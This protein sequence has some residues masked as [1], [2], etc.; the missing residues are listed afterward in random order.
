[1]PEWGLNSELSDHWD[2]LRA[3]ITPSNEVSRWRFVLSLSP[4]H[5]AVPEELRECCRALVTKKRISGCIAEV[6]T[7]FPRKQAYVFID[8]HYTAY[9]ACGC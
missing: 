5:K 6:T 9:I 1:M 7:G 3:T 4:H 8:L 2:S